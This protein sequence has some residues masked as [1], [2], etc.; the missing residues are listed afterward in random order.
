MAKLYSHCEITMFKSYVT[1]SMY[2]KETRKKLFI[3]NNRGLIFE[4]SE[5][6]Q[7]GHHIRLLNILSLQQLL[8]STTW[9]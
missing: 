7:I 6:K 3:Q 8:Y 9:T 1:N 4:L 5:K 2:V